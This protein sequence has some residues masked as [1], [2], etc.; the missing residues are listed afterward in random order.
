MPRSTRRKRPRDARQEQTQERSAYL[1]PY[2]TT[3]FKR[4]F[5]LTERLI[6]R[7]NES[8]LDD[9]IEECVRNPNF[10][11]QILEV[12]PSW[13]ISDDEFAAWHERYNTDGTPKDISEVLGLKPQRTKQ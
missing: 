8:S 1:T 11:V 3:F 10:Y 5:T 9:Y 12:N 13:R 4:N 7:E 6:T 2:T